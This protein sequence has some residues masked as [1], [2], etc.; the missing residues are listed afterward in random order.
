MA[1]RSDK[2]PDELD[3]FEDIKDKIE[4][5]IESFRTKLKAWFS[6]NGK[7]MLLLTGLVFLAV[8]FGIVVSYVKL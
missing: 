8:V 6:R 7:T 5:E 3:F 2:L 4:P 1:K